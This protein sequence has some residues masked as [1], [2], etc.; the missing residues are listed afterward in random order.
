MEPM[1]IIIRIDKTRE[2]F[3]KTAEA[4]YVRLLK[5]LRLPLEIRTLKG[6]NDAKKDTAM[7]VQ[8]FYEEQNVYILSERGRE[9]DS[10]SFSRLI[11]PY[12]E[13]NRDIHFILSG[14]FGWSGDFPK[15]FKQLSLSKLTF[16]HEMSY[17]IL[18][19]QLYRGIKITKGQ[20]YHY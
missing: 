17:I 6:N 3:V 7:I 4:H 8:K 18:L 12:K 5:T 10:I 2:P 19:E 1:F 11:A 14:P 16:T 13:Q 9:Y 15:N 20:K